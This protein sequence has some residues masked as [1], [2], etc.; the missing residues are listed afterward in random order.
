VIGS[1][2]AREE[3]TELAGTAETRILMASIPGWTRRFPDSG[4][5][6]PRVLSKFTMARGD[7]QGAFRV[8]IE[9]E[10]APGESYEA[11]RTALRATRAAAGPREHVSTRGGG[12]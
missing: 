7:T 10:A 5:A 6:C 11:T 8:E 1:A 4:S 2:R 3:A 12:S 9:S